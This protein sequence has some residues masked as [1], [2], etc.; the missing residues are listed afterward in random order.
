MLPARASASRS[1]LVII[2][3]YAV[4]LVLALLL[5][6]LLGRYL[7]AAAFGFLSMLA[8]L[9]VVA[10]TFCDLGTSDIAV[11]NISLDVSQERKVLEAT[12]ALRCFISLPLALACLIVAFQYPPGMNRSA[13]IV[14]A[15]IILFLPINALNPVFIV[16]QAQ[17]IP[18]LLG[19]TAL[20][21]Y[22]A[23]SLAAIAMEAAVIVIVLLLL[24]R[25]AAILIGLGFFAQRTLGYIALPRLHWEYMRAMLP[26]TLLLGAATVCYALLFHLGSFFVW[27]Q[28]D[29]TEL[30]AYVAAL[31]LFLPFLSLPALLVTPLLPIWS[32]LA[33]ERQQELFFQLR[34]ALPAVCGIAAVVATAIF[35]MASDILLLL[36]GGIYSSQT[37]NATASLRWLGI[38]F[39]FTLVIPVLVAV[40]IAERREKLLLPISA[41]GLVVTC[42][43][44]Y[45]LVPAYGGTGAALAT[46]SGE[47]VVLLSTLLLCSTGQSAPALLGRCLL[48][49]LPA[50]GLLAIITLFD[51]RNDIFRLALTSLLAMVAVGACLLMPGVLAGLQSLFAARA[52]MEP[53]LDRA[54][55]SSRWL[56]TNY[57]S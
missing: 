56:G 18:A 36:Y 5:T 39:A 25:E 2:S 49:C 43:F 31:R 44:S 17:G 52:S 28:H 12:M 40:L 45:F 47:A 16:R 13:L 9:F 37:L 53:G 48:S 19:L 50:V 51:P 38:A 1:Q 3:S 14:A 33:R 10:G 22:L 4:R 29:E 6:A 20:S 35:I 42:L 57:R 21:G 55:Q 46:L 54:K 15:C 30:G 24:L 32:R 27:W 41:S 34:A 26:S 8:V 7:N 11:R 23:L